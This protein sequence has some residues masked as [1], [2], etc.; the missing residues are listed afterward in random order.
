[1]RLLLTM[2]AA[3][4]LVACEQCEQLPDT[5]TDTATRTP[6]VARLLVGQWQIEHYDNPGERDPEGV[7]IVLNRDGTLGSRLQSTPGTTISAQGTWS[8]RGQVLTM[9]VTA[10]GIASTTA[11]RIT[12]FTNKTLPTCGGRRYRH[13]LCP[14]MRART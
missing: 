8:L 10:F 11:S 6:T 12:E 14:H 9:T 1:M 2:A 3:L 5:D 4:A 7:A 13:L